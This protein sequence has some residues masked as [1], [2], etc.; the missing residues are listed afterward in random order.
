MSDS[1]NAARAVFGVIALL[2][3]IIGLL[4]DISDFVEDDDDAIEAEA[5]EV[6]ENNY[7]QH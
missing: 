4:S 1:N 2:F 7:G 5:T 3:T 6:T